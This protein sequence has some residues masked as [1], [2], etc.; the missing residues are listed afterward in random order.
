MTTTE[1]VSIVWGIPTEPTSDAPPQWVSEV[2]TTP[3]AA[4]AAL[5]EWNDT[6]TS[7]EWPQATYVA[8]IHEVIGGTE[9]A[10]PTHDHVA[11]MVA[12]RGGREPVIRVYAETAAAEGAAAAIRAA[13][14]AAQV[15]VFTH[16]VDTMPV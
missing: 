10:D 12:Y 16:R 7:E 2:Y 11:V 15:S 14:P 1:T 6:T 8:S 5:A 13:A 9:R 3:A 4:N